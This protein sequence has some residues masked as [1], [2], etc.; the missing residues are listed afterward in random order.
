[1]YR[2]KNETGEFKAVLS[3]LL[4]YETNALEDYPAIGDWVDTSGAFDDESTSAVLINKIIPRTSIIKRRS[5]SCDTESQVLAA[6]VDIALIA[7]SA[8]K[9]LNTNKIQRLILM[10]TDG[11][12]QPMILLTKVDLCDNVDAL[13][14]AV[15]QQFPDVALMTSSVNSRDSILAV[16]DKIQGKTVV[17]LGS[18]GVGKSSLTN[19]LL[20]SAIQKTQAVRE[21]DDK[22]RHTTSSSRMFELN[23]GASIIDTPGLRE[24][25]LNIEIES[26]KQEFEKIVALSQA[27]FFN[28]CA[29]QNEKKCAVKNAIESGELSQLELTQFKKMQQEVELHAK[30]EEANKALKAKREFKKTHARKNKHS[31]NK[32]NW[33]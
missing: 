1:V 12:V 13:K 11:H 5:A 24:A 29:H 15:Q 17:L 19:E 21:S 16:E 22:G 30:K 18:S 26:V 8:N 25:G 23:N 9:E 27:C 6:N 7:S 28:N 31:K 14:K 33:E 4:R 20:Q 2:C 32:N 3:G 10:A